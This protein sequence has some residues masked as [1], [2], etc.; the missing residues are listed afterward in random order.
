[1][2]TSLHWAWRSGFGSGFVFQ[3][4]L[5]RPFAGIMSRRRNGIDEGFYGGHMMGQ[6]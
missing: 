6:I 3:G 2:S 4:N 5:L 1:M